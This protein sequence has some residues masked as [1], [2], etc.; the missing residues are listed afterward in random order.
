MES[1]NYIWNLK[2]M[3]KQTQTESYRYREHM[4]GCQKGGV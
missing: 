2:Q 1:V 4:G 3:N